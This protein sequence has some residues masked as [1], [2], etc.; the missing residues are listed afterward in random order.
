M[1]NKFADS[2]ISERTIMEFSK[3]AVIISGGSKGIG[4]SIAKVFSRETERP[5][6]LI[7]RNKEE[8]EVAAEL[9]EKAGANEV[10][11][12][13]CDLTDI[14]SVSE[15]VLPEH[16]T[17]GIL[18]N[19]AGSFLPKPLHE[20]SIEEFN[21]QY[22]INTVSA[23]NL[24]NHFLDT[25]KKK[26][27]AF[28]AN[29]CSRASLYGYGDAGAYAMSKHALLGYTR[30]LRTELMESGIAVT[31]L[32]LGQ[33]FSTSWDGSGVDPKR[34][35]NPEDIGRLIL[36]FSELSAQSVVEEITVMPQYGEL[37]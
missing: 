35:I 20:T 9:C 31:A 3:T 22:S 21:S 5:I 2:Q 13:S 4:L 36:A 25:F 34:L 29:I 6:V 33:T 10:I 24:T 19:N 23:F 17:P 7:A 32:N 1:G 18:I 15:I 28:I 30:S 16:I 8:L 11:I 37:N 14:D 27:R 26:D 12:K